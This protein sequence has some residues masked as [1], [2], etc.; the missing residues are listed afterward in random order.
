MGLTGE[1]M[2]RTGAGVPRSAVPPTHPSMAGEPHTRVIM[3]LVVFASFS[4]ASNSSAVL[5]GAAASTESRA[6][7][8]VRPRWAKVPQLSPEGRTAHPS[9]S[10]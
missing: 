1:G 10:R 2:L 7:R 5:A 8:T 3:A 6:R 4:S 9:C